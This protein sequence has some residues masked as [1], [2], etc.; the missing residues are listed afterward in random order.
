MLFICTGNSARSIMAEALMNRLGGG[1]FNAY[2]AGPYPTGAVNPHVRPVLERLGFEP[3]DFRSKSWDEFG[4]PDAPSMDFIF[5]LC[6]EAGGRGGPRGGGAA[7]RA[8]RPRC[9]AHGFHL[10]PLRR[11]GGRSAARV[12]GAS[13]DRPLD[14]HRPDQGDR[15]RGR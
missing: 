3:S 6:D 15:P 11:S 1:R 10:P 14:D 12:A 7:P 9:P 8:R 4:G 2:S 13:A 5:T